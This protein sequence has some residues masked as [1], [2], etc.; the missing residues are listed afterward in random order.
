MTL[1]LIT[2]LQNV[3]VHVLIDVLRLLTRSH[4]CSF[5]TSVVTNVCV[6]HLELMVTRKSVHV[7]TTG[8]LKKENQSALN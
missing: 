3:L 5:A 8:K 7:I 6:S 1:I 4:V 2:F